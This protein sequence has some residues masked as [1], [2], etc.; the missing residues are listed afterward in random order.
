MQVAKSITNGNIATF[1]AIEELICSSD[2]D[3]PND[4]STSRLRSWEGNS[5]EIWQQQK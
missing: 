2:E 5:N 1:I 3:I 4:S